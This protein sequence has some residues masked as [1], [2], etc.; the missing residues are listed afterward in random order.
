MNMANTSDRID[1]HS[2]EIFELQNNYKEILLIISTR[3][4]ADLA[5]KV[6]VM[7]EY[8][9]IGNGKPSLKAWRD[10]IDVE[11]EEAREEKKA[12]MSDKNKWTLW[13]A[14]QI[15]TIALFI[16]SLYLK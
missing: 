1:Q 16:I 12:T 3:L 4:P 15:M 6:D 11:R 5:K 7:Y 9:I 10:T 8:F 2:K 13:A 14:G